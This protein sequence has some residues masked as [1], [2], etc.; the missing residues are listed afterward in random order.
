M[1]TKKR[2]RPK[3]TALDQEKAAYR[4][5]RVEK[6]WQQHYG[7]AQAAGLKQR[8]AEHAA[9]AAVAREIGKSE[10][11]VRQLRAHY[12]EV[13]PALHSFADEVNRIGL[14]PWMLEITRR[15]PAARKILTPE[16][17]DE[18]KEMSTHV[19][20]RLTGRLLEGARAV[21]ENAKL[22]AEIERLKKQMQVLK[23]FRSNSRK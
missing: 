16:E 8:D 23:D 18:M 19:V 9:T 21:D 3:R 20:M 11:R 15:F 13:A 12:I 17:W 14:I 1:S 2:G 10:R 7:A 22:R 6:S 5:A 4:A